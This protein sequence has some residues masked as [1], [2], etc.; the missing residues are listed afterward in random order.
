MIEIKKL[1]FDAAGSFNQCGIKSI[2]R[3]NEV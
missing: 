2:W 3:R 1:R